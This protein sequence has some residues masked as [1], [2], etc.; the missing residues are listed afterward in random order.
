MSLLISILKDDLKGF[1]PEAI[2][3]V[4]GKDVAGITSLS[5]GNI[6]ISTRRKI[7]NCM[8]CGYA[9]YAM[10]NYKGGEFVAYCPECSCNKLESQISKN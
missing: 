5:N 4:D 10:H 3:L 7:G 8:H 1:N 9:V 6:Y 2:V